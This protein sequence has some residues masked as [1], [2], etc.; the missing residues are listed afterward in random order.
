ME[1]NEDEIIEKA[2]KRWLQRELISEETANRLRAD[3][4][5]PG[6][7]RQILATYALVACVSCGL[8][9]F[10]TLVMDEKWIEAIRR[11]F[12]FSEIVVGTMFL[13][14]TLLF[15][16]IAKRR[17][18]KHGVGNAGNEAFS[19]TIVLSMAVAI[20]Y[21][22]R[23]IGYQQGNYAPIL[24]VAALAYGVLAY[25]LKVKFLWIVALVSLAGWWG[26]QTYYWS[27]GGDYF[28]AMNYPL[29]MTV[30]GL[31]LVMAAGAMR[32]LNLLQFVEQPTQV[33][34]WLAL[35]ISFWSLSIFGNSS[36]LEEWAQLRQ[37]ALWYWALIFSLALI[38]LIVYSF[39]KSKTFL[40]DISL[41][42]FL[43]NIYTRYFEYFWDKTHKGLFFAILAISFWWLG[44]IA[45]KWRSHNKVADARTTKDQ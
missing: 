44:R 41:I 28:L 43:I 34:A 26:A 39:K 33:F 32:K 37:G 21:F 1:P 45:E 9:A 3:I 6:N 11:K 12:D 14:L 4:H 36:S 24:F 18:K 8:L 7:N 5:P 19:I 20:A 10:G 2:I 27:S 29:R 30:F 13:L 42:F 23:S 40:R 35:L 17:K 31:I 38:A 22:G 25:W 15:A 16:W